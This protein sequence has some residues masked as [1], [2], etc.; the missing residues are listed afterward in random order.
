M[1][2]EYA[3]L[4]NRTNVVGVVTNYTDFQTARS[5]PLGQ[6]NIL[7]LRADLWPFRFNDRS[8]QDLLSSQFPVIFTAR[9]VHE[10][11]KNKSWTIADRAELY[12]AYIP[13]VAF[14]DIEAS[15]AH[16][17]VDVIDEAKKAGVGVIISYHNL[18]TTP[19]YAELICQGQICRSMGGDILKIAVKVLTLGDLVELEDSVSTLGHLFDFKV[20]A[21]AIGEPYGKISRFLDAITGGPF[22]YGYLSDEVV[23]GQPKASDIHRLLKELEQ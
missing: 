16:E 1:K 2:I 8:T 10:G 19:S 9:N 5:S 22:I 18:E 15:T 17:L 11:G 3:E 13:H 4:L 14:I 23:P 7:E 21:M 6:I 20:S 12:R